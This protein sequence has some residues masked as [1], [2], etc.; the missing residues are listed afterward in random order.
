MLELCFILLAERGRT[1]ERMFTEF[2][3]EEVLDNLIFI[4]LVRDEDVED[5]AEEILLAT[6]NDIVNNYKEMISAQQ[7]KA[8]SNVD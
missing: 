2:F 7:K 3:S 6:T 8:V 4:S 1:M 5:I